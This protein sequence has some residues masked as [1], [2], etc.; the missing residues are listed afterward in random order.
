MQGAGEGKGEESLDGRVGSELHGLVEEALESPG[1]LERL[2]LAEP[3]KTWVGAC[4]DRLM[5]PGARAWETEKLLFV[6][7]P[8]GD[9]VASARADAILVVEDRADIVDWKF[10]HEELEAEEREWQMDTM[11]CAVLQEYP[12]LQ[13]ATA[14]VYYPILNRDYTY[15]TRRADLTERVADLQEIHAAVN[16]PNPPLHPGAWCARCRLLAR[17]PAALGSIEKIAGGLNLARLR[18]NTGRLPAVKALEEAFW[19]EISCWSPARLRG[20]A[21]VLPLL[22]PLAAAI[23]RALRRDLEEDPG[24]HPAFEL[25]A[26]RGRAHGLV[27]DLRRASR[28]HLTHDEFEACMSASAAKLRDA[29]AAKWG[30]L[31]RKDARAKAERI[32]EPYV[33]REETTELRR[34]K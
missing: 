4:V 18:G 15:I 17:C 10:Y 19:G 5:S 2:N 1:A 7:S 22:T 3:E 25:K 32:L 20:A 12:D 34:R 13:E 30:D 28:K 9:L 33:T 11:L 8:G 16:Q 23:K 21:E 6:L 31:S 27:E 29:L 24:S 26:K 14:T